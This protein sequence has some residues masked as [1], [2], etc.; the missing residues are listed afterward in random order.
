MKSRISHDMTHLNLSTANKLLNV[1]ERDSTQHA[2]QDEF[3]Q[4]LWKQVI[5]QSLKTF[6]CSFQLAQCSRFTSRS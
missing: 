4:F 1:C 6:H 2:E 3:D 5:S